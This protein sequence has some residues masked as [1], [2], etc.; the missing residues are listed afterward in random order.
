MSHDQSECPTEKQQRNGVLEEIV[1][2][3]KH[4]WS[5]PGQHRTHF[6][7]SLHNDSFVLPQFSG[8]ARTNTV[9]I[10][11][12]KYR[13]LK[14]NSATHVRFPQNLPFPSVQFH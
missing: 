13:Q 10:S 5:N 2:P 8:P 3:L 4:I 9:F 14:E 1:C 7:L 12:P 6:L 11:S